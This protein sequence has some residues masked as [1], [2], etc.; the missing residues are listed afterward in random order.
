MKTVFRGNWVDCVDTRPDN[1]SVL[2]T[3]VKDTVLFMPKN[4]LDQI[5]LI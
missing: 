1:V 4:G 2:V 3:Q 5:G